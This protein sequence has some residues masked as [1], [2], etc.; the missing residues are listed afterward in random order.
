M[1]F[2][3]NGKI[4]R[5]DLTGGSWTVE[6]PGELF[7]RRYWG[8]QGFAGYYLLNEQAAGVDPLGPDNTLI[9]ATGVMTGSKLAAMP[10]Y[11]V[12][13]RSPLT[14]LF[15]ESEAGGFWGPELK[16]A[17]YDAIVFK[18]RAEHPVY[19]WIHDGEVEIRDAR[20]LWGMVTGRA[21][22]AIRQEVG[23]PRA[24]VAGIG[25]AGENLVRY[26]CVMNENKHANGRN[27]MGAVM[28]S[29]NLK[30]IAVR[31]K[32]GPEVKDP[33]AVQAL[34][35]W[36]AG[37]VLQ[38]PTTKVLRDT[39]TAGLV[40][41]LD[42]AGIF[43]TRNFQS[44]TFEGA[45]SIDWDAYQREIFVEAGSCYAC[46]IRCKR[47]VESKGEYEV[48]PGYGGPEY[49]TIGS[50]GSACGIDNIRA[51]AKA[52][53][54]CNKYGL[55]T[56]STGMSIAFAMECFENGLLTPQECD[57]LEPRFGNTT[58]MLTLVEKIAR[59]DGFG[60]LLAEGSARAAQK[61][62]R[63]AERFTMEVKGQE[64]P[65]HEPRGK[66]G[67]GL[68][69]AISE[70]GADHL[71]IAHDAG[72]QLKESSVFKTLAPL[73][74]LEPVDGLDLGPRKVRLFRP[75]EDIYA[76]WRAA[77]VCL[78]GYAP[79]V[80]VPLAKFVEMASAVTGWDFGT[81]ELLKAGER[82][83]NLARAFNVREGA[84]RN[85][86][87]LPDRFFEP[88]PDGR[89][90]GV[91]LSREKLE[92]AITLLYQMKGWDPATGIPSRARLEELD[93]PWVSDVLQAS[94]VS[95]Q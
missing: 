24:R 14:G 20:A 15:G 40:S 8:G 2:G 6:E 95:V 51:I 60:D 54:L 94:G 66:P 44:G 47:V 75:L 57:G 39:G 62:G 28:G 37:Q 67:V 89:L 81:P 36:Y 58:A 30:A 27:G 56:I 48:D 68:G 76:F 92:D 72:F 49:E 69:Y 17:G 46:S 83:T 55:D 25:P 88:L 86:D 71:L 5:V 11:S 84:R 29:K 64:F 61:I 13:A 22:E 50:F 41:G 16:A 43:P 21:Q 77:G 93:I 26:A 42:A 34:G 91:S 3:Y 23:E 74:V 38:N 82:V 10:R 85:L 31:G 65:M 70:I 59:R 87:R 90:K 1:P 73:G 52:N 18:G 9:F 12:A 53:E 4:L 80:S 19:L 63:G 32:A 78:F 45:K 79:R 7:F 33:A 35:R